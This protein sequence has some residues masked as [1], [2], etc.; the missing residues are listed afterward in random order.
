VTDIV[1]RLVGGIWKTETGDSGGGG[2]ITEIESTDA[3][4]TVTNP[5]GPVVDLAASGGSQPEWL[6]NGDGSPFNEVAPSQEGAVYV[7]TTNGGVYVAVGATS[8]DWMQVGGITDPNAAAQ[9][10]G[11]S[12]DTGLGQVLLANDF[13]IASITDIAALAGTQ[14]SIQW[15]CS[16]GDGAQRV[17]ITLGALGNK[18]WRFL[19]DGSTSFPGHVTM[20]ALPTSDPASAGKLWNDAGTLKISA[21]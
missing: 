19:A 20:A 7:D 14:N 5:T 4:V 6:M 9:P 13:D 18:L 1:R 15:D 8:A 11:V 16:S 12:A 10:R 17:F 2:G 21:G 3:S